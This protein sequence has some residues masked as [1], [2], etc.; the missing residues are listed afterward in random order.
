MEKR[1][2]VSLLCCVQQLCHQLNRVGNKREEREAP[3]VIKSC[4]VKSSLPSMAD[5]SEFWIEV[6]LFE[7]FRLSVSNT[8][9]QSYEEKE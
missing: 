1:K 6:T 4:M 2:L 9:V 5:L 3:E 7:N 8:Y